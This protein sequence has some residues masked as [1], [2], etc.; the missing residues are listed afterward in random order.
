MGDPTD[1]QRPGMRGRDLTDDRRCAEHGKRAGL[2]PAVRRDWLFVG[3]A[4]HVVRHIHASH[5]DHRDRPRGGHDTLSRADA[6]GTDDDPEHGG[7]EQQS[8]DDFH[9]PHGVS[10]ARSHRHWKTSHEKVQ[11]LASAHEDMVANG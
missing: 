3:T 8:M 11:S 9:E 4:R 1:V 7:H 6:H 10:L 5:P 2:A